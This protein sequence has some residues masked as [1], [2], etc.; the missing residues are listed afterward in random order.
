MMNIN[1][2]M[3][4]FGLARS[5]G[6]LIIVSK[7]PK[8]KKLPNLSS[9]EQSKNSF[10]K[11]LHFDTMQIGQTYFMKELGKWVIPIRARIVND[12]GNVPLVMTAGINIDGGETSWNSFDINQDITVQ[13]VRKDGFMQFQNNALKN[14]HIKIYRTKLNEKFLKQLSETKLS[15]QNLITIDPFY[16]NEQN[17]M[18][19]AVSYLNDY[20][21]YTIVS[22]K[23]NVLY[24][25]I[26]NDII[27]TS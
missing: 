4:G 13:I 22:T 27:K 5:D 26:K 23:Y 7:I 3:V 1:K 6:Q 16:D 24:S 2:G 15:D 19:S 11:A 10:L 20:G 17:K 9:N 25:H 21:L 14:E 18:V 12:K 8:G